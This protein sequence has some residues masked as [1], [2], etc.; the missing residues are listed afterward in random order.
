MNARMVFFTAPVGNYKPN[1][2][3]LYDMLGNVWE[4]VEDGFDSRAY[5]RP[6]RKHNPLVES[7]SDRVLRGGS[8]G[9]LPR[10]V[11]SAFRIRNSPADRD[12]NLGFRL[13]VAA[14]SQ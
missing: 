5:S 7:G 11:R 9:N 6:G 14:Q 12:S 10:D 13:A 2:F 4:W 1:A 8:W 3:G